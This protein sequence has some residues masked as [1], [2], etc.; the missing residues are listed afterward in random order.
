MVIHQGSIGLFLRLKYTKIS[1]F[2]TFLFSFS[3]VIH[4]H[5]AL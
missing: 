1:H 2:R 5:E 3:V 4:F